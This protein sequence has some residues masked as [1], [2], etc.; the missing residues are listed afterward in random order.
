MPFQQIGNLGVFKKLSKCSKPVAPPDSE[1]LAASL[2]VSLFRSTDN[3]KMK[4]F[5]EIFISVKDLSDPEVFDLFKSFCR[6]TEGFKLDPQRSKQYANHV[7]GRAVIIHALRSPANEP[8]IISVAE[9]TKHTLY[10]SNIVPTK[11]GRLSM[12]EYNDIACSFHKALKQY[13]AKIKSKASVRITEDNI[14][15]RQIIPG[16]RTRKYFERYLSAYP[17]S[18]HPLDIER[19]DFFICALRRYHSKVDLVH[20]KHYLMDDLGW[21]EEDASW[22]IRRIEAGLDILRVNRRFH[23]RHFRG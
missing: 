6:S 9:R 19:L 14:G 10:V 12:D 17:L 8:A 1:S 7:D 20:L 21:K 16:E 15:L 5:R 11:T 22:C 13:L 4:A 23:Y 18:F 2:T 3:H